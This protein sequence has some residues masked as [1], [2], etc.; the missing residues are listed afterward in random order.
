MKIYNSLGYEKNLFL[1]NNETNANYDYHE[2]EDFHALFRQLGK[3]GLN[4]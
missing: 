2:I 4:N 3:F 1:L